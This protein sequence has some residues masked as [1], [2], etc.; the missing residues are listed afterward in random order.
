MNWHFYTY[1]DELYIK[2]Q[3]LNVNGTFHNDSKS[4]E[5]YA[6]FELLSFSG[7][8]DMS[9]SAKRSLTVCV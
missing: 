5:M 7:L 2:I 4:I 8:D 3:F 1:T 6:K 9:V